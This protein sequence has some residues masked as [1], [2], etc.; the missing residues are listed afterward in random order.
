LSVTLS[1]QSIAA[2]GDAIAVAATVQSQFN[3]RLSGG[4][5]SEVI[6]ILGEFLQSALGG[7]GWSV[8]VDYATAV[9]E[10]QRTSAAS[11]ARELNQAD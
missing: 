6:A 10:G 11:A 4:D 8:S 3:E 9:A 1:F 5:A 2:A 7:D